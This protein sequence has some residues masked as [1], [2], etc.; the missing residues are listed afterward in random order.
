MS[1]SSERKSELSV[2]LLFNVCGTMRIE[3][4]EKKK[5]FLEFVDDYSRWC[6][7]RYLNYKSEVLKV[8]KDV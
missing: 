6:E 2:L 8:T 7:V 4:F 1:K 3:S 5:Y